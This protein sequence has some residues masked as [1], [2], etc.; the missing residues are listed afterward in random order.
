MMIESTANDVVVEVQQSD[1]SRS[2]WVSR[3]W[4]SSASAAALQN[5][6][7]IVVP[8]EDFRPNR[9]A[10]FPEGTS[11]LVRHLRHG[12]SI[13]VA[14]DQDKYEEIALYSNAWRLPTLICTYAVI[15]LLVNL[16]S[17]E[18]D[19]RFIFKQEETPVSIVSVELIVEGPLGQCVSIKYNGPANKLPDELLKQ[20]D[21]CFPK[22]DQTLSNPPAQPTAEATQ[23]DRPTYQGRQ[24]LR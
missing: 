8:W 5:A 20:V 22:A 21:A 16:L 9:P 15:P 19:R 13:G 14:I 10:L 23:A 1:F 6:D 18:V 7:V 24:T 17:N 11:D 3:T 12:V 4:M 2:Y